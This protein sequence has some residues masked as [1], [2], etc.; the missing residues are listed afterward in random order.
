MSA[1][2]R[3]KQTTAIG[4][5]A[6][7]AIGAGLGAIIGNQTGNAGSGLAI[8][9]AAGAATGSLVGNALQKQEETIQ[10]QNES[11]K[12]QEQ[13]LRAQRSEV[14]ELRRMQ[15]DTGMA[16]TSGSSVNAYLVEQKR[17]QL[18]RRGPSP[19]GERIE[20]YSPP[21]V[22]SVEPLARYNVKTAPI[23]TRPTTTQPK[24]APAAVAPAPLI[25][26]VEESA[27]P[28]TTTASN[29]APLKEKDLTEQLKPSEPLVEETA[30]K[31]DAQPESPVACDES[32]KERAAASAA[33][34]N[35][36]KLY[37][38]R[39]ALRLCPQSAETHYELGKTYLA[40]DRAVDATFEF[41]QALSTDPSFKPAQKELDELEG[42][43]V[44]F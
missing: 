39:R 28:K 30:A 24:K 17:L 19:R 35:S 5:A 14:A 29:P 34:E 36:D 25:P 18:Q 26:A 27:P 16:P 40:M 9:A 41:K 7:T 42:N 1:C 20:R 15:S 13:E 33:S 37:H 21:P 10:S 12:R 38:L 3:P 22:R 2:T 23:A 32:K 43:K 4:A 44:K 11:I 31:I 8:G 6:G